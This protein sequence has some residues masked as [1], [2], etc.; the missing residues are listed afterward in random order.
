VRALGVAFVVAF[1]AE[2]GDK[3]QLLV[4]ALATRYRPWPVFAVLA[5][6]TVA[7]MGVSVGVGAALGAALP[8]T[9]VMVGAGVLFLGFAAWT[10]RSGAGDDDVEGEAAVERTH[11]V[12]LGVALAVFVAELGDKT[13]LATLALAATQSPLLTWIGA[14]IG[15]VAG[16]GLALVAG[17]LLGTR[18]PE[19]ATRFGAAALFALFGLLLLLEAA[20]A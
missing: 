8:A 15:M 20:R 9:A 12:V 7:V 1:V 5:L 4:L 11:S 17:S 18:L 10:L 13:M 14:S 3:S 19:R 2:L 16:S 6:G